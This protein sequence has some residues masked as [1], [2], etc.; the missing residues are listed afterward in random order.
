MLAE[1]LHRMSRILPIAGTL[2]RRGGLRLGHL[3]CFLLLRYLCCEIAGVPVGCKLRADC[4]NCPKSVPH[5]ASKQERS[6]TNTRE[7]LRVLCYQHH[8]ELLLKPHSEP[9]EG[10]LYACREPGCPVR[11][12]SSAGYFIDAK[13]AKLIEQETTPRVSCSN[14]GQL[15]YL[16]EDMPQRRSFRL[17]KCPQCNGSR[18]N[19]ETLGGLGKKMGA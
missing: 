4:R 10:M 3:S 17:W 13:E 9:E 5:M 11:Y 15:M 2:I 19:E 8:T 16:A 18:T 12:D 7:D 6:G 14:D 1:D